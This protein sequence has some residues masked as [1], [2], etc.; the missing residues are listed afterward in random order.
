MENL[1]LAIRLRESGK[2][3]E[4]RT[5]LLE[6][7][8]MEPENPSVWYQC[9]WVHDSLGLEKEAVPFYKAALAR[10]LA[11][12]EKP[13]AYL[14]LGS[15]FRALGDYSEARS[16]FEQAITEFP[17]HREFRVFLAMVLYNLQDYS[18]AME[19]LLNQLAQTSSDPGIRL[20]ARAIS[21]Y[22]DKLDQRWDG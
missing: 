7:V 17:D 6:L 11:V 3:E 18:K 14:G 4:A 10:G 5:V 12:E 20:Y 21:Y 1:D 13:G 15:T 8:E 2:L 9:A 19:I 22:A 16:I